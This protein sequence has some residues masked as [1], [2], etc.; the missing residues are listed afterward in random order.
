MQNVLY[1]PTLSH[2]FCSSTKRFTEKTHGT[3]L[4]KYNFIIKLNSKDMFFQVT[5]F[6]FHFYFLR[7]IFKI[8]SNI[9]YMKEVASVT[10]PRKNNVR[11]FPFNL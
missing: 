2:S 5:C 1:M 3:G 8:T 10:P 11:I 6:Q 9:N 4:I 7:S